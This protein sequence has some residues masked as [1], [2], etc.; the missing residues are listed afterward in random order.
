MSAL[1][2]E[3]DGMHAGTRSTGH[4]D[5]V[6]ARRPPPAERRSFRKRP[7][8]NP[9]SVCLRTNW[10]DWGVSGSD[11][12]VSLERGPTGGAGRFAAVRGCP[13]PVRGQH[14]HRTRGRAAYGRPASSAVTGPTGPMR[15]ASRAM[16]TVPPSR[17]G[18]VG[19]GFSHVERV[20]VRCRQNLRGGA[21]RVGRAELDAALAGRRARR[22]VGPARRLDAALVARRR[23]AVRAR[24]GERRA[25]ARRGL[26]DA[27]VALRGDA[28]DLGRGVADLAPALG[29]IG[30]AVAAARGRRDADAGRAVGTGRP[31]AVVGRKHDAAVVDLDGRAAVVARAVV[32]A[33]RGA[34]A[35]RGRVV[36]RAAVAL[37]FALRASARRRRGDEQHDR[38]THHLVQS[39][40]RSTSSH[41]GSPRTAHFLPSDCPRCQ[42]VPGRAG[43]PKSATTGATMAA[44]TL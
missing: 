16:P 35:A 25:H 17:A 40:H 12:G 7:P 10:A 42:W 39:R 28:A 21:V 26:V 41:G 34:A 23:A 38:S 27:G 3:E 1:Q 6:P 37:H 8:K 43:L 11:L 36:A 15:P 32:P 5:A 24:A 20:V 2:P 30:P 4:A 22:V 13:R 9:K 44:V 33:G 18:G 31:T 14:A 19:G 29:L